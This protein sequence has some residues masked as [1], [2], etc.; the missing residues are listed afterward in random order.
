MQRK[1]IAW[2]VT[3]FFS[4]FSLA[5]E[6]DPDY[7]GFVNNA[8][9]GTESSGSQ[10]VTINLG[11]TASASTVIT[12]RVGGT[13]A[14]DGDYH[15]T[16]VSRYFSSALTITVPAGES[17]AVINFDIIDDNQV[18]PVDEIIYFEITSI[19]DATIAETF[20]QRCLYTRLK[21]M[22]MPLFRDFRLILPGILAMACESMRQTLIST[23]LTR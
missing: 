17:A 13:A 19:S 14:L 18:E 8:G 12:Y 3:F 10:A 11:A 23:S 16:S 2:L 5:C 1:E 6:E 4:L 15:L 21:T 7:G 9:R 22:T 20:R